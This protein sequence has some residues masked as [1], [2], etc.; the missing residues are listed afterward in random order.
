VFNKERERE[1]CTFQQKALVER[2]M[3]LLVDNRTL[4]ELIVEVA[5]LMSFD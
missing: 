3:A 5:A 4:E 2:K 1:R